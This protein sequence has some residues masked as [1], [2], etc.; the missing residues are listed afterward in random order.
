MQ[1]GEDGIVKV[2]QS[3]TSFVSYVRQQRIMWPAD[4]VVLFTGRNM[5]RPGPKKKPVSTKGMTWRNA[6]CGKTKVA[7]VSDSGDM[8]R[9][10]LS[11]AHEIS[12]ALGSAHD[13]QEASSGCPESGRHLMNPYFE[14]R[15]ETYSSCSKASIN[16]FLNTPQAICL[17]GEADIKQPQ[18]GTRLENNPQLW[19]LRSE[20]CQK[21]MSDGQSISRIET[22]RPCYFLCSVSYNETK[23]V[24]VGYYLHDRDHTPCNNE[25]PFLHLD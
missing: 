18:F 11:T 7:I 4:L 6:T 25:N 3:L 19:N 5:T 20:A 16:A 1:L 12:H 22:K 8:Y 21:H 9:S 24:G 10:S 13:G 17:F 14:E 2:S 15:G 23:S